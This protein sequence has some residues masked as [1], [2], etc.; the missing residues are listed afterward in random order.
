[1]RHITGHS[2]AT[3]G[4]IESN[5]KISGETHLTDPDISEADLFFR[6]CDNCCDSDWN[7]AFALIIP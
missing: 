7:F 5:L 4:T 1:M 2:Y 6:G 3:V